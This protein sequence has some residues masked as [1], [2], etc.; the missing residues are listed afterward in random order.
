MYHRSHRLPFFSSTHLTQFIL[1]NVMVAT[2][3]SLILLRDIWD[4]IVDAKDDAKKWEES[5]RGKR[6]R[7][8]DGDD[9]ERLSQRTGC[10]TH[11]SA[12][13]Q[14]NSESKPASQTR[15][16]P[17]KNPGKRKRDRTLSGRVLARLGKHDNSMDRIK[18]WAE[19]TAECWQE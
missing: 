18:E 14:R 17:K 19:V 8:K 6:K 16:Q 12:K 7:D 9:I 13:T 15:T 5:E 10:T 1:L 11:S 4:L 2:K 3:R